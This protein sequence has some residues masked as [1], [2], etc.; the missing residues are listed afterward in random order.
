MTARGIGGILAGMMIMTGCGRK[1]APEPAVPAAEPAVPVAVSGERALEEVR[2][3]TALGPRVSGT[4]GAERAADYL[5]GRLRELGVEAEIEAF[6]DRAPGG[7]LVFRN[8]V[9][10]IPGTGDGIILLGS[11]YDTKAGIAADFEGA[12]DSGSSTGLLLELARAFREGAPHSMEIRLAFFDGEECAEAYGPADGLH[13]SRRLAA[14]ME[15]DGSLKAVAAMILLDMVGDRN[16][17][18]TIPRNSTPELVAKA[19]DAARAEGVRRAF[20][21]YPGHILDDHVPFLERGV[22]AINLIDFHYG[23]ATGLND[24]WHTPEDTMDKLSAESLDVVGRV[25]ARMV[26]EML[27]ESSGK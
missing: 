17:T 6:R 2:N 21:L 19:F 13:G 16:L 27:R 1:E 24:W 7:E 4:E 26:R 11:H 9:G 3:F 14:Q 20:Q 10:R 8:V 15:A 22:P 5:A 25:T 18:V 23:S 12:N